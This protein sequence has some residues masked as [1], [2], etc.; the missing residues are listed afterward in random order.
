LGETRALRG[1]DLCVRAG[2]VVALVGPNGSGKTTLLRAIAGTASLDAGFVALASRAAPQAVRDRTAIAGLVPQDPA[3]ALSQP[4]VAA[5]V[6]ETRRH[7]KLPA[8]PGLLDAWQV[9]PLAQRDP[10]DLS[11]GQQERVA[12]A[13]MLAHEPRVWM[14][15]EPTRGADDAYKHWLAQ[16]L[17]AHAVAGGAVLVTTHDVEFAARVATRVAG[18]A[19]GALAFDLPVTEA[20]G[21]GGPLPSQVARIVPG[22]LL[23]EEVA[24]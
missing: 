8:K 15:D 7:R 17:R 24:A 2:E 12:I 1:V 21:H 5:E 23:A 20:L 19:E 18:L 14:L 13:A 4:T 6:A 10:R 16:R 22:V 3:L 11:V 9:A